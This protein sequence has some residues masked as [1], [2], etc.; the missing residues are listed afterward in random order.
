MGLGEAEF[1]KLQRVGFNMWKLG[2]PIRFAG[3]ANFVVSITFSPKDPLRFASS[4]LDATVRIWDLTSDSHSASLKQV[5]DPIQ[6][7]SS[8]AA[9]SPD[10]ATL[11]TS[12]EDIYVQLWS[13]VSGR[14]R[15]GPLEGHS[16]TV[17]AAAWA[18]AGQAFVTCGEDSVVRMWHFL[19]NRN[20]SE[21]A[22]LE[23][24]QMI[25]NKD[26]LA[27]RELL[28]HVRFDMTDFKK[29]LSEYEPDITKLRRE[30]DQGKDRTGSYNSRERVL[31]LPV[32][33]HY[34]LDCMI[35]DYDPYYK[36]WNLVL[37]FQ[38]SLYN[39]MKHPICTHDGNQTDNALDAWFKEVFKLIKLFD[40]KYMKKVQQIAKDLKTAIESFRE[41]FPFLKC[42]A[43]ISI[44]DR[45][46][47]Q[48]FER[49]KVKPPGPYDKISLQNMLDINILEFKDDFEELSTAASKE[50]SLKNAMA[51][52]KNDWVPLEFGIEHRNGVAL[53]A[54]IDEIQTVLDDH[55]TMTQ[56]IRSSPFCK[57]FEKDVQAWEA[58][59]LYIQQFL[60]QTIALQRGRRRSKRMPSRATSRSFS[61]SS[62]T[63]SS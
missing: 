21:I 6:C 2:D 63:L 10:A 24:E 52:M 38:G 61:S 22:Q 32:S 57:P 49:M 35:D 7:L 48:L 30:L 42:Y 39:W 60:D 19:I 12:T 47:N 5:V 26:M 13:A 28:T 18:P 33:D 14:P 53:L 55:I 34:E 50:H 16:A 54:G 31:S 59:L 44:L 9:W 40:T 3:H 45:H 41:I 29:G 4:S 56:A 62:T 58:T 46:W 11:V 37:V 43:N 8:F 23:G 51:N 15:A 1:Y 27:C 17:W 25:F 36:L 20:F